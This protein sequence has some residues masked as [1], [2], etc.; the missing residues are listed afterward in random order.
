VGAAANAALVAAVLEQVET[1]PGRTLELYAGSGNFTRHLVGRADVVASDGD[2][3]ALERGRAR[4][5]EARWLEAPRPATI[6]EVQTVLV[7]PPREGLDP[8]N[9]DLARRA[10]Q[11]LVYV[12]CDPQTL[13]RDAQ[14]LRA[15]GLRLER[16]V[17]LDLMPQ[18]Y[19]VEVVASFVPEG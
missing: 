18:T 11:R 12:S 13:G 15:A 19:H 6:G 17:A 16:A 8:P 1:A 9:L 10:R 4:V 3:A 7:D 2:R 14:R 5:P